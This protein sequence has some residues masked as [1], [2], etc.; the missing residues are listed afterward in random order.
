MT[1]RGQGYHFGEPLPTDEARVLLQA[2]G[3]R[4]PPANGALDR[5]LRIATDQSGQPEFR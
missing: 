2:E 4:E 3:P 1:G 5:L